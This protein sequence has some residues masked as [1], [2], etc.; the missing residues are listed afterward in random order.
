ML[1]V[2]VTLSKKG[3]KMKLFVLTLF[4]TAASTTFASS[5]S[6]V[7]QSTDHQIASWSEKYGEFTIQT[8]AGDL[9]VDED[10]LILGKSEFIDVFPAL[11]ITDI[12]YSDDQEETVASLHVY[13]DGRKFIEYKG[14]MFS[15]Y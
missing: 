11:T 1:I 8:A 9:F 14:K 4:L 6:L 13:S 2:I 12:V 7:C 3:M 15:C 10:A 5:N